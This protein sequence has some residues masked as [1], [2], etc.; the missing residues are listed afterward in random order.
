[1]VAMEIENVVAMD[2]SFELGERGLWEAGKGAAADVLALTEQA[3]VNPPLLVGYSQTAR[4]IDPADLPG[5]GHDYAFGTNVHDAIRLAR[6]V[7]DETMRPRRILLIADTQPTS[8]VGDSGEPVFAYTP[9]PDIAARTVSAGRQGFMAGIRLDVLLLAP[10]SGIRAL[11]IELATESGGTFGTL[12]PD[13]DR[14]QEVAA[15]L[16]EIDMVKAG[17]TAAQADL[18]E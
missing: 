8:Y 2:L 13:G 10:D 1:M 7:L 15:F 4:I 6:S 3:G 17:A 5:L 18:Q 11:A 9:V 12:T 16:A 14:R